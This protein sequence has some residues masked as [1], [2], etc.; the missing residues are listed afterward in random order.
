M[1]THRNVQMMVASWL[2]VLAYPAD[3]PPVNLAA[4]PLTHSAGVVSLMAA[5]RGGTVVILPRADPA[6]LV[7]AIEKYRVTEL[8]LPPT[9]IYMMLDLPG[10][11][12]RD[13]SS[14]R[15]FLYAAAPMS[16]EKLRRALQTFGPVMIQG[17]GQTE[18]LAGISCLLPE[19]HFHGG[20]IAPE[21]RL[22]SCGRPFPFVRCVIMNDEN[23]AVPDGTVGEI[24]V[25][26]DIVMSGYYK[27]PAKTAETIIDGW[28]HTGDVG[29]VDAAGYL[30]IT[31]RKKDMIITGGFNVF[32]AEVEGV[33]TSHPAVQDCAVVGV[34]DEKWGEAVKAVVERS[35][36][37]Q[38]SAEEIIALCRERLGGVKAPKSVDFV[39]R[40][41]R[42]SVGKVLKREVRAV[43][44]AGQSRQVS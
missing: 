13:Y 7:D 1:N 5:A 25:R 11:A 14:L 18:A 43:Y 37:M 8:F 12:A 9:V 24:C 27:D 34:P 23:R 17:Y 36:G 15:Y 26:G 38:V 3:R 10:V 44:W 42:S 40:L 29:F 19:E 2:S 4:A 22:L 33:I 20:E 28:L 32:S 39:E 35:P 30:H 41:P 16:P 21:E 6:L 31:D